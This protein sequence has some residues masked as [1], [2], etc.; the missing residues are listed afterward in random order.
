MAISEFDR[1]WMTALVDIFEKK[2]EEDQTVEGVRS[3]LKHGDT[4]Y[5]LKLMLAWFERRPQDVEILKMLKVELLAKRKEVRALR[6]KYARTHRKNK[7]ERRTASDTRIC[8]GPGCGASLAGKRAGANTCST[9]CRVAVHRQRQAATAMASEQAEVPPA[10][11]PVAAVAK[12]QRER[13]R[14]VAPPPARGRLTGAEA[15]QRPP[16][17]ATSS[18]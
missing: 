6:A 18:L 17:C 12:A 7:R 9:R 10:L 16:V 11:P 8:E 3:R 15:R 4:K 2:F 14:R 1:M 13:Q 5:A